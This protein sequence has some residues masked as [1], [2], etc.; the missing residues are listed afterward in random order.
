M[1]V[2]CASC[3]LPLPEWELSTNEVAVCT[4]CGSPN[5]AHV[6]PAAL[7]L[8]PPVQTEVA[9]E[10]E[11]A[12]FDH[13]AKR[14]VSACQQCGRYVCQLCAVDFGQGTWCPSCVAAG[15]GV[16][17]A[18]RLDASRTLFDSIAFI[19][20]LISLLAWPFTIVTGPGAVAL[21]IFKWKEPLSLVR[22][23]R[24]RFL[25]AILIGLAETG[26]WIWGIAYLVARVRP[27]KM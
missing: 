14:A 22:R 20:P 11:A 2:P 3:D 21:A 9:L 10:G 16:A 25:A 5:Q 19:T 26:A 7:V 27:G 24:W 15:A 8:P 1:P 13:P 12:C 6:F 23:S 18:A 17:R 4:A